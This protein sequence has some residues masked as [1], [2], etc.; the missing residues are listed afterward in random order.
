MF[1]NSIFDDYK[2]IGVSVHE[3]SAEL[4][5]IMEYL[6][7]DPLKDIKY[8]DFTKAEKE[9][10]NDIVE[11][12]IKTQQPL[13]QILG[14][15]YFMGEKF[16]VNKNTLIPR[17]ETEI[18]VRECSKLVSKDSKVLDIGTGT[19]CIAIEIRKLTGAK[20][21]AVDISEHAIQLARKNAQNHNVHC[22]FIIS[23]LFSEIKGK[24]D[25][26][27][28]NPPYIP[29]SQKDTLSLTVK[30]YEPEIALYAKDALGIEFYEK[31]INSA[32]TFLNNG[33]YLAFELGI[34][35]YQ[36]IEKLFSPQGFSNIKIFKDLDNIE[37]VTIA[38]HFLKNSFQE[39]L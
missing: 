26:I 25:L 4:S 22:N 20:V 29:I 36:H 7:I 19:G 27:V 2:K 39:N 6:N 18:L 11:K 9:K 30:K 38:Q 13:Q 33:G 14:F 21:D 23:D 17:P 3:A 31:I 5:M 8:G 37:R 32:V 1:K 35:Q 24:Y 28:S 10:I 15:G 16:L 34:N 12:R